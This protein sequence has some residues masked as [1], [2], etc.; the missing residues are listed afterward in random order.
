M[1]ELI[2]LKSI[3]GSVIY[4]IIGIAI[5]VVAYIVFEKITPENLRK[6]IIEKQNTAL[7]IVSAS[8]ILAIA[9]IIATAIHG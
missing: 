1:E 2:S 5:L 9:I 3:L 4:S 7:A 6:E 8:F